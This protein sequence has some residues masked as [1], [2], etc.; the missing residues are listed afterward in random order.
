VQQYKT[1]VD[2]LSNQPTPKNESLASANLQTQ[3][4]RGVDGWREPTSR[5]V[6]AQ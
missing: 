1:K 5:Q 2:W 6:S 4:M 3:I